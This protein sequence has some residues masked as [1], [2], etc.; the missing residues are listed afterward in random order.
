MDKKEELPLCTPQLV[1]I[2][3]CG[4]DQSCRYFAQDRFDNCM[5]QYSSSFT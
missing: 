3:E 1:T 2:L 5:A 4:T